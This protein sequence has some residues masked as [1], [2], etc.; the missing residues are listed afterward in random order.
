MTLET[1]DSFVPVPGGSIFVRQW[2]GPQA[3]GSPLVLLH[4]SLGSVELWRDFPAR[5]AEALN[6][7]VVAYDRLGFGQSTQ[8]TDRP[9]NAFIDEEAERYFPAVR[10]AL[11]LDR[12]VL[13]GHSV[14]GAMALRI[15]ASMPESC[16]AVIT[17]SA[18][19]FVEQ[20]TVEG[21]R[22]AQISFEDPEQLQKLAKRHG[23]RTPWVLDAWIQVW[24]SPEFAD[25]SLDPHLAQVRC[26]VLAIHGDRDEYGSEAF[27]RR[28]ASGVSGP[29]QMILLE[30]CGHVPHRERPEE[31][32]RLIEVFADERLR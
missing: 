6:R 30:D 26:P 7:N 8:R 3:Q 19:C 16:E 29:V 10:S 25:W 20:R 2:R 31:I 27:P 5:L 18:Q 22:A 15:A 23:E 28:I 11:G 21:I 17:E 9:S 14:G 1:T 24:L 12:F 4:D 13:F 32:L